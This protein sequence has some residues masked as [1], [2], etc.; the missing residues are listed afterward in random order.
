MG[1][2]TNALEQ[3][4]ITRRVAPDVFEAMVSYPAPIAEGVRS[5][6]Y[7][8]VHDADDRVIVGLAHHISGRQGD[9]I[10]VI[11]RRFYVSHTLNSMQVVAVAV[12]LEDGSVVFYAN[13]TGTDLVT[14]FA[15]GIAK[16]IGG[17]LMRRE[18]SRL[19]DAFEVVTGDR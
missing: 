13:R 1:Q 5:R 2:L 15:S 11:E 4:K 6:F 9:R 10:V 12:P 16:K 3:L 7:W 19:V 18:I 17:V 8:V 14:G